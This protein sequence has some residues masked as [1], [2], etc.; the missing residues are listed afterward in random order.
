MKVQKIIRI[1]SFLVLLA[2]A[3]PA[4][5]ATIVPE[6]S[7]TARTEDARSQQLLQRLNDI[8]ALDKSELTRLDKK[9]LRKEVVSI[10]KEMK[11]ITGGI[12]LSAAAVI[13]II[14]VLL[15]LL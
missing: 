7:A 4:S 8:K 13:I 5:S 14:L 3:I 2:I 11:K 1:A 6:S 9:A 15:L 10:K 12:Y